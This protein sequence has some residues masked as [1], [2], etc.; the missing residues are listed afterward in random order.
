MGGN[1]AGEKPL[2]R[3]SNINQGDSDEKV[4]PNTDLV[5]RVI[6]FNYSSTIQIWATNRKLKHKYTLK[7]DTQIKTWTVIN[8]YIVAILSDYTLG[9]Y[10]ASKVLEVSLS[11]KLPT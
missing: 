11:I 6:N 2:Y 9:I 3:P 1:P 10:Y 5:V 4:V 8:D 7:K